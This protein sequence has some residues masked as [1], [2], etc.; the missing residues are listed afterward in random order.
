MD[1]ARVLEYKKA[2]KRYRKKI[3]ASPEAARKALIS[4]GIYLENGDLNPKFKEGSNYRQ[5]IPKR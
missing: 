3:T 2:L 4:A 1:K 5:G